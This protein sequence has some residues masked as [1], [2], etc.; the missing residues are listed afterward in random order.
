MMAIMVN[1]FEGLTMLALSIPVGVMS[2][3]DEILGFII[4]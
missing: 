1:N 4:Y 2:F 3:L